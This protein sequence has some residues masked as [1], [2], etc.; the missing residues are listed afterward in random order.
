MAVSPPPSYKHFPVYLQLATSSRLPWLATTEKTPVLLV[1]HNPHFL[2]TH[3][4]PLSSSYSLTFSPSV[5][6]SVFHVSSLPLNHFCTLL[7]GSP[8]CNDTCSEGDGL[9]GHGPKVTDGCVKPDWTDKAPDPKAVM[10]LR[11]CGC[12]QD[13]QDWRCTCM[14]NSMVCTEA[15]R[16]SETWLNNDEYVDGEDDRDESDE[17]EQEDVERDNL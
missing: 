7:V 4:V 14:C 6:F 13:C 8:R 10:E 5:L 9:H 11:S 15:C 3:V 2:R 17:D 1:L 12:R 16:C